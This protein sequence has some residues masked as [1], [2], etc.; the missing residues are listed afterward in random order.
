MSQAVL[1]IVKAPNWWTCQCGAS[2]APATQ[3]AKLGSRILCLSCLVAGLPAKVIK[4]RPDGERPARPARERPERPQRE[5]KAVKLLKEA[6]YLAFN[7]IA[8]LSWFVEGDDELFADIIAHNIQDIQTE[9]GNRSLPYH[10]SA[11]NK[12]PNINS[13]QLDRMLNI[14]EAFYKDLKGEE[15]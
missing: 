5:T 14:Y 10:G 4:S 15:V 3:C 6:E 11:H 12:F 2:I 8:D 1:R 9:L 7:E 13:H